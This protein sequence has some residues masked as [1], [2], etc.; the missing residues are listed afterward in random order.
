M[1]NEVLN[2]ERVLLENRDRKY[3]IRQLSLARDINY[4]SAYNAVRK[5]EEAGIAL[6]ERSGNITH[7]SFAAK[8]DPLVYEVEYERRRDLLKNKDMKALYSRLN[9]LPFPLVALL[10]GSYAK[11]TQ[12]KGSDIDLLVVSDNREELERCVSLIPLD[13]HL[14]VF[15]FKEFSSMLLSK[16]FSIVSEAVKNNIIMVGIEDYYR[17]IENAGRRQGYTVPLELRS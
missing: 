6:C 10:F 11:K 5:L 17:L 1:A 16:E 7:C 15:S 12:A 2:I 9:E 14:N 13:I 3:S 4:K 8:L